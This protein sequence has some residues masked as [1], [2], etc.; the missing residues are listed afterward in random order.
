MK[1]VLAVLLL[2]PALV[3]AA[4]SAASA[5][6]QGSTELR[7]T[8]VPGEMDLFVAPS[9]GARDVTRPREADF[10]REDIRVRHEP[11]FIEPLTTRPKTGPIKKVGLSGWTAPPGRGDGI[12]QHETSGWFSFGLSIVWE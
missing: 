7:T 8:A 12:V 2:G 1:R 6:T 10:Y 9:P 4:A 11:G 5:Q 3:V